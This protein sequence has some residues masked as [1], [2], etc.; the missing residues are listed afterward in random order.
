MEYTKLGKTGI[1]V[2]RF[3]LGCMRFP[4]NKADAI[5]MVR[6]AIDNGVNYI[7]TAYVYENSEMI[8]G[9]ALQDGYR[10]RIILATKSPIWNIQAHDDFEKYLDEELKRLRMDHI[11]I[12]LLHNLNP[13]NWKAVK[14]YDGLSFLDKMVK[15]GKIRYKGFSIH[16]TVEVFKE[17]VDIFEWEMAQIQLNILGETYQAG[18]E[19]LRYGAKK[20][21]EH[22]S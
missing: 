4:E 21:L 10:E 20:G 18:I 13:G 3:G 7:D 9:E 11:D 5:N 8:T 14:K 17:I 2:S 6:Y 16:N 22:L 19:G 1:D 12:Y 15:K